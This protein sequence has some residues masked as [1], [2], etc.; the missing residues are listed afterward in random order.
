MQGGYELPG[1]KTLWQRFVDRKASS[2]LLIQ[3]ASLF[4][5]LNPLTGTACSLLLDVLLSGH[6]HISGTTNAGKT[7]TAL[8]SLYLQLILGYRLDSGAWSKK[9][10]IVILDLKGD[11]ALFHA[12]KRAA[13]LDGRSFKFVATS[14]QAGYYFFD[15]FQCFG[16]EHI[17]EID[18]AA[19]TIRSLGLDA[20]IIYAGK[21]FTDQN[22]VLLMEALAEMRRRGGPMTLSHLSDILANLANQPGKK[23]A[24]HIRLCI[25]MLA[26]Y[27][28]LNEE[29]HRT[30]PTPRIDFME[31]IAAGD[32]LYFFL[33]CIQGGSAMRQIAAIALQTVVQAVQG[34]RRKRVATGPVHVLIDEF[35]HIA[36]TAFGDLLSTARHWDVHFVLANQDIAQLRAHDRDLPPIV[37]TNTNVK[38]FFSAQDRDDIR[39]LQEESGQV[40]KFGTSYNIGGPYGITKN[41]TEKLDWALDLN[42]IH[43]MNDTHNLSF[44]VINDGVPHEVGKRVQPIHTLYPLSR[45]EY[46]WFKATP[47]PNTPSHEAGALA[48]DDRQKPASNNESSSV[49]RERP[50]SKRAEGFQTRLAEMFAKLSALEEVAA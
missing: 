5:G 16:Y 47:L 41:L 2:S 25:K 21:Y 12:T 3:R 37:R 18:Q 9:A 10:P 33:P 38:Q 23:D 6:T 7:M 31:S 34:L 22:I 39:Y 45:L 19:D 15:P 36:S 35:H 4:L 46:E 40:L 42:A 20:G 8:L 49:D 24:G 11:E 30:K 50:L 13:E 1:G 27:P 28:Q 17:S 44:M 32:V 26:E 48:S 43:A 14:P 29:L